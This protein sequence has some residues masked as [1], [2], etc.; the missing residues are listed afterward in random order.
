MVSF[1][2]FY[3]FYFIDPKPPIDEVIHFNAVPKLVEF[4]QRNDNY[5]LQVS[6]RLGFFNSNGTNKNGAN[7]WH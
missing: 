6:S 5:T 3:L 7:V 1:S 2:C 4:L